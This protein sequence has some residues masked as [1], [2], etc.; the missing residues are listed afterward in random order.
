MYVYVYI[1]CLFVYI[2]THK[3]ACSTHVPMYAYYIRPQMY[4]RKLHKATTAVQ[5]LF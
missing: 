5:T 3:Y 1:F 4:A 2:C